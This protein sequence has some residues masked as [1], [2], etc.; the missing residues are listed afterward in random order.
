MSPLQVLP[1]SAAFLLLGASAAQPLQAAEANATSRPRVCLVLSGGG[2]RGGAHVGVLKVLEE[3]RIPLDCIVGTSAGAAIGGLYAS[4]QSPDEIALFLTQLDWDKALRDH[5][6]RT[7][8]S[9]RRKQDDAR[10]LLRL[11][12]GYDKGRL[13]FPKGFIAGRNLDFLLKSEL[14]HVADIQDFDKLP[15]PFRAIATDLENGEMVVLEQGDLAAALR[16]SMA[17]PGVFAPVEL[18]GRLLADGGL[19]RNLGVDV[20]RAM[21]A[22]VIIAVNAGTLLLDRDQ[23]TNVV[24]LSFQVINILTEQNVHESIEQ[25]AARDV[26]IQPNL[27][28]VEAAEFGEVERAVVRGAAAARAHVAALERHAVSAAEYWRFL[29]R[30]RSG[31]QSLPVIHRI[32]VRSNQAVSARRILSRV[33]TIPG[34]RLDLHVLERDLERVFEMGDFEG[35]S[36]SI[37]GNSD[38]NT[39]VIDVT[40]RGWGPH[41]LRAG[42]HIA[43][44]FEGGGQYELLFGHTRANLNPLGGEWRNELQVGNTRRAFTEFFQPVD[45]AGTFFVAPQLEYRSETFDLFSNSTRFAQYRGKIAHA[46]FDGGWLAGNAGEIRVGL[47]GGIARSEPRIGDPA[48]PSFSEDV[49][50]WRIRAALD[51]LDQP[52]FPRNGAF[53][54][55]TYEAS[56]TGLGADNVYERLYMQGG[57]ASSIGMHTVLIAGEYGTGFGTELPLYNQFALGGFFSLAGFRHE[58]LRGSEMTAMRAVY[59]A[60]VYN[61]PAVLGDGVYLGASLET[62]NVW[63][64]QDRVNLGDLQAGGSL[65]AGADTTIGPLYL[66]VGFNESGDNAFYLLLGRSF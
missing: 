25:L 27:S 3:L 37:I 42:L 10:Y 48:L 33:R 11:E 19:V 51:L 14:L 24:G 4:G 56:R 62:G 1:I 41:Y 31:H 36:F 23:L 16:A 57:F 18:D 49:G 54:L 5:P 55:L 52:H 35:V 43:E 40:E 9:F 17:V 28:E 50:A 63:Q 32:E 13:Y 46:V 65:F 15:V 45:Y 59:Y 12:I 44:D 6:T 2:A 66:G 29:T 20:A 7:N 38:G 34:R 47:V 39:L 60:R 53:G 30:Q 64:N 26:L 21:Q 22:D 58:Q 61:L 8:L